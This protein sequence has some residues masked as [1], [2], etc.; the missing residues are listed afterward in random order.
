MRASGGTRTHFVRVTRAVP[1]RSSIAGVEGGRWESN[2]HNPGSQPGPATAWVR[3]QYPREESNLIRDLRTVACV[4]HTPGTTRQYPGQE[5][6]LDLLLRT[7][8]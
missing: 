8:P 3:P 4:H 7:E 2:P 6:N 1:G 5:S